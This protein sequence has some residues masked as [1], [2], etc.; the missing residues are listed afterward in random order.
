MLFRVKSHFLIGLCAKS[1]S[2]FE[3]KYEC[4]DTSYLTLLCILPGPEGPKWTI[5][6]TSIAMKLFIAEYKTKQNQ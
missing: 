3:Q 1:S 6:F 4:H 2:A 5:Y